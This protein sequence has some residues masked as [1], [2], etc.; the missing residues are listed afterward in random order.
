MK[1]IPHLF[2][3]VVCLVVLALL[4][5]CNSS[6][7]GGNNRTDTDDGGPGRTGSSGKCPTMVQGQGGEGM[8]CFLDAVAAG[9]T[10]EWDLI[11]YTVEG[12]PIVIR[13][14]QL[15]SGTLRIIT[16][17]S[18]DAFGGENRG[19]TV[20]DCARLSSA[21]IFPPVGESCRIVTDHGI[22]PLPVD[23]PMPV[24]PDGGIGDGAGPI[25]LEPDLGPSLQV[26]EQILGQPRAQAEATLDDS[27]LAWRYVFI[28]GEHLAV[29]AD[30]SPGRLN[31]SRRDDRIFEVEVEGGPTLKTQ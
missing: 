15:A 1:S 13:Y 18:R 21:E 10:A 29:T 25:P 26:A 2:R 27:G 6:S 30:F 14:Q 16:D 17:N 31:L 20:E 28:E 5:A 8:A 19:V 11:Q 7:N 12:D 4:P 24:E 3:C 22:G 23:R 9:E